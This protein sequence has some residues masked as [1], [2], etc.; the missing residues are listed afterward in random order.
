MLVAAIWWLLSWRKSSGSPSLGVGPA[1]L[2]GESQSGRVSWHARG[3]GV[4]DGAGSVTEGLAAGGP[5][6]V[7]RGAK[8]APRRHTRRA[9]AAAAGRS[10]GVRCG[11]RATGGRAR[12]TSAGTYATSSSSHP[13]AL[14]RAEAS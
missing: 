12:K 14:R 9:G 3:E 7:G 1:A 5:M 11:G 4:A 6:M 13:V 8:S 10:A 2:W